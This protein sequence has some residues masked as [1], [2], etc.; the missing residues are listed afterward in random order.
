MKPPLTRKAS[1]N[2]VEDDDD[3]VLAASPASSG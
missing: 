3:R 1:T 2:L